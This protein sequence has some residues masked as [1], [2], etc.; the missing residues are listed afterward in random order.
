MTEF[1]LHEFDKVH[2]LVSCLCFCP[3][4][5]QSPI[6]GN[7]MSISRGDGANPLSLPRYIFWANRKA[8]WTYMLRSEFSVVN[9][10][11]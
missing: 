9:N 7:K 5:M 4:K 3:V 8:N 10:C 2:V 6:S 1:P 11:F